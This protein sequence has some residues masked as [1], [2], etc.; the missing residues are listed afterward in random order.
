MNKVDSAYSQIKS[1][2]MQLGFSEDLEISETMLADELSMSR[3]PV[4]AALQ[5][6]EREGF[7]RILPKRGILVNKMSYE[8]ASQLFEIRTLVETH[9]M[10]QSVFLLHEEDFAHLSGMIAQQ[11][12][13]GDRSDYQGF[14][15]NDSAFH[16]YCY[17]HHQ[18]KYMTEIIKLFRERFY[19]ER[20]RTISE[21]GRIDKAIMEHA[22][23]VEHLRNRDLVSATTLLV[24]HMDRLRRTIGKKFGTA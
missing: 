24:S 4:R 9:M 22:L 5:A 2:L 17:R 10:N 23:F 8:E 7:L 21:P 18:N 15:E 3:T 11:R 19:A 12:E 20:L 14:L 13:C 1:K 6:L 16:L